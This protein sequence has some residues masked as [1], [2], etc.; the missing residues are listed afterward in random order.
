MANY[1][2]ASNA[3]AD[4]TRIWLY[5]VEQ[6]GLDTA[7]AYYTAFFDHFE[8]LA[9]Q[10]LLYPTSDIRG[11]YRRSV[12]GKDS[13]FYRIEGETVEIMAIIGHQ[14]VGEWL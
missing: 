4:L 10:P 6:W 5:G 9:A 3:K 13:V 12:C 11:G 14:D 7:D 1:R 8:Q 2:L